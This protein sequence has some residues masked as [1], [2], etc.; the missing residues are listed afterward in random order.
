MQAIFLGEY[1]E[2]EKKSHMKIIHTIPG[3][4]ISSGGPSTCTY[5]L[6]KGMRKINVDV[7][8]LT[9]LPS[10]LDDKIIGTDDFIKAIPNDAFS[11]FVISH[12]F[13]KYLTKH[14]QYDLYHA[15]AIWIDTTHAT[16]QCARKQDKPCI[17]APHGMLY[18]QALRVSTWKKRI[19]LELF[20]RKDL[21]QATCIQA[22]CMQ[23]FRYIRNFGFTNPVA[24]VPNCLQIDS[25]TPPKNSM[26]E[27]KRFGFVGR[28]H[29]IKN[30]DGLIKAWIKLD[31]LTKDAELVIVGSGDSM[32]ETELR[33]MANNYTKNISF[34]GF[35][36]GEKLTSMLRTF[37]FLILSSHSENFGMVVPEALAMGIPVIASK[38]TPWEELDTHNCGWWVNNDVDAL[39]VTIEKA[40]N[41]SE[42]IR[43]EMGRNGQKLV[44]ENYSVEVVAKKM[45]RLYNW[46]LNLEQKPEFVF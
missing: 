6:T 10:I 5:N 23:E 38:G 36:T 7:D 44:K 37:D 25:Y 40:M 16:V 27:R 42:D 28:L 20:Q 3:L 24:V 21:Q 43:Q 17:I 14:R 13:R 33:N 22:T 31:Q 19:A 12:N 9:L 39:A 18:P 26:N 8:I 4:N 35:L 45:F 30:V 34:T 32:H 41:T 15:N 1:Y 46:I 2:I 11:P 29:R